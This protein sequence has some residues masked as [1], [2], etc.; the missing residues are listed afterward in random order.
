MTVEDGVIATLIIG[1]LWVIFHSPILRWASFTLFL[2]A[3]LLSFTLAPAFVALV[4]HVPKGNYLAAGL[5]LA[6]GAF[7]SLLFFSSG[8][9]PLLDQFK[10][11]KASLSL[12]ESEL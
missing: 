9:K 8:W 10:H 2:L 12:W 6:L 5:T 4:I 7:L 3:W 1:G 11:L